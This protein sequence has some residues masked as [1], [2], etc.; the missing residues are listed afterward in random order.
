MRGSLLVALLL[1]SQLSSGCYY[2]HLAS[3]QLKILWARQPIEG[4]IADPEI[5]LETR[6]L[7]RLVPGV[8]KFASDLGLRVGNQYTSYVD[9]PEDRIVTTVVRTRPPSVE[10]TP[11]WFPIIGHLPYKG[12]FDRSRAEAE[13]ERLR[14]ADAFDVCVSGVTAYS[15]LGW[16]NDPVTAPMLRR[17]AASLVETLLHE[18]VHATAFVSE[19]VDF[20]ESVAQ[21]IGQEAAIRFFTGESQAPNDSNSEEALA[22]VWPD[23]ERVRQS[24]ED[25]RE[26]ARTTEAFRERLVELEAKAGSLEKRATAERE[27]R[28]ELAALPLRV[29]D[30]KKVAASARLSNACL[31]LR[32]AYTRD[33][34]RHA[35]VLASLDGDLEAMIRRL[36]RVADE[37]LTPE[38]FYRVEGETDDAPRSV[39]YEFDD[40]F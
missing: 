7:L 5:P 9:W 18:L 10:A 26:I 15:T 35:D 27:T 28:A 19:D 20:N 34:P 14:E 36:L 23:P 31:A 29:I 30:P 2:S 12:Y 40:A 16:I 17:G 33:L 39:A 11:Y 4:V 8:R 37:E 13:A 24:I 1:F 21:F 6:S 38:D 25:R 3:G 32:G 22:L